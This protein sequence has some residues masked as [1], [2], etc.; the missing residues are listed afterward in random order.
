MASPRRRGPSTGHMIRAVGASASDR[1]L[2]GPDPELELRVETRLPSS[3]PPGCRTAVFVYGSC[4]HRRHTVRRIELIA[5]GT[6]VRADSR[7]PRADV[8]RT[9]HP[10]EGESGREPEDAASDDPKAHSFRSG[11]W[12][13]IRIEMPERGGREV[14]LRAKLSNDSVVEISLG[15][16]RA[17]GP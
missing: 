13:T 9:L 5:D 3:S 1:C 16:I 12:T 11:F 6:T 7:M 15:E 17:L 8:H 4:F 10:F 14:E 2:R